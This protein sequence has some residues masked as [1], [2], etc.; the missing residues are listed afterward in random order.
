MADKTA[1][2]NESSYVSEPGPP[3]EMP[4]GLSILAIVVAIG[5]LLVVFVWIVIQLEPVLSD[6]V[7]SD[8]QVATATPTE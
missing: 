5:L 8:I 1:N 7:A 4:D 2:V 3:G 6:F